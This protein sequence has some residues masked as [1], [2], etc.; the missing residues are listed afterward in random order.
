MVI[1]PNLQ[2]TFLLY[3]P[4]NQGLKRSASVLA[5]AVSELF[6]LYSPLNQGLKQKFIA[7][8]VIPDLGFYSTV[9]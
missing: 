7:A 4:L 1:D 6:L 3:S 9:H 5:E 8:N 2:I